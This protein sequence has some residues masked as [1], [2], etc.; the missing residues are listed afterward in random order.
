ME[1]GVYDLPDEITPDP[2]VPE[3]TFDEGEVKSYYERVEQICGAIDENMSVLADYM[4]G[5]QQYDPESFAYYKEE[6][7]NMGSDYIGVKNRAM[8]SQADAADDA[9]Q[10]AHISDLMYVYDYSGQLVKHFEDTSAEE[11]G[12][13]MI[14]GNGDDVITMEEAGPVRAWWS[15]LSPGTKTLFKAGALAA[16]LW[17]GKKAWDMFSKKWKLMHMAEVKAKLE[18]PEDDFGGDE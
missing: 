11:N 9:T 1:N 6:I 18:E 13:A 2:D 17:G 5:L 12:T 10:Q 7:G 4:A 16:A 14:N 8:G 3:T 15:D